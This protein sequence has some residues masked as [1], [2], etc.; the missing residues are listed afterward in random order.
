LTSNPL[1][2]RT[3]ISTPF[4]VYGGICASNEEA[5]RQLMKAARDLAAEQQVEYLELRVQDGKEEDGFL[6]KNLYV[7]FDACLDSGPE[8]F[9]KKLPKDTRYMIRKT[10]K[11]GL[12][13]TQGRDQIDIFYEIYA[14]SVHNLGTPVFSKEFFRILLDEFGDAAE[15]MVVWKD[16]V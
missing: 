14:R 11:L 3:M 15:I 2:G 12:T 10:Q 8:L 7:T 4:A 9:L 13:V 1:T 6:T 16:R 5:R